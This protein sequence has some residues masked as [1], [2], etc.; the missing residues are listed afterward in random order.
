MRIARIYYATLGVEFDTVPSLETPGARNRV[1]DLTYCYYPFFWDLVLFYRWEE[2][3]VYI[4]YGALA[5]TNSRRYPIK[6]CLL[7]G[8]YGRNYSIVRTSS[9]G[10]HSTAPDS[11][12]RDNVCRTILFIISDSVGN[13]GST[14]SRF[15]MEFWEQFGGGGQ[16]PPNIGI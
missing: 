6:S 13:L 12:N 10:I 15:T 16:Q 8:L 11:L 14:F 1:I 2:R 7:F 3:L 5:A 4:F 9:Q